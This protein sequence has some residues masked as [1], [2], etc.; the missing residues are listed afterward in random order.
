MTQH[1]ARRRAALALLLALALS[2]LAACGGTPA[3]APQSLPTAAATAAR[4]NTAAQAPAATQAPAAEMPAA[5]AAAP[6]AIGAAE[7]APEPLGSGD[8]GT[9]SAAGPRPVGQEAS[10]KAGEINDNAQFADY[11]AYL[12]SYQDGGV[13]PADV[14]ERYLI[15]VIDDNQRP[16]LDARVTVYADEQVVFTGRTYAGGQTIF[17]PRTLGVSPNATSF[18]AVAEYG[19]ASAET[20]FERSPGGQVEIGL[21]GVQRDSAL[22]LDLLFLLDTTGSMGDELGRI[23]QTIDSIA[24]RIDGFTPR[25]QIR[26]GLVAY[27]DHGDDYV[28]SPV[29]FTGDLGQFR[30]SLNQ[31]SAKGGGDTPE[32]VDEAMYDAVVRSSWS[33]QPAVRLVFLV[34]D[35]GPHIDSQQQF[36]YLDGAREAAARGVKIYP[37]AASNTDA[38]AE[39]V[40]RQLAQQT[41]GGFVFLTYQ[42]GQSSGAPGE[43]TTLEAGGQPYSVERLDDLIVNIVEREL[44]AAVGAR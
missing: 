39:Y 32:A 25:P 28:T 15:S 11:L 12:R 20:T 9:T 8:S 42:P 22:R 2:L 29:D 6:P 18:R 10:L 37:I 23:Q 35:A 17:L 14:G 31:L 34:A 40:F 30:A 5:D 1:P 3:A 13:R 43:S 38:P 36:T 24:Q 19:D 41:M 44:A 4:E 21:R 33:E 16:V 7:G 26:Y 27:K